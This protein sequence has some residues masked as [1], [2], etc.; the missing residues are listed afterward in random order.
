MSL[1]FLLT[2]FCLLAL[3]QLRHDLTHRSTAFF[4]FF[5]G[6]APGFEERALAV[7]DAGL[8]SWY[9]TLPTPLAQNGFWSPPAGRRVRGPTESG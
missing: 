4:D 5:A 8:A 7:A 2:A 1:C 9:L 6:P 3:R